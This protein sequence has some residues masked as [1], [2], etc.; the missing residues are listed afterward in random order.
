MFQKPLVELQEFSSLGMVAEC[1]GQPNFKVVSQWWVRLRIEEKPRTDE[2]LGV[3]PRFC[4][5]LLTLEV[6]GRAY[7]SGLCLSVR[8]R[9][10]GR[11][12]SPEP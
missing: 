6:E 3:W 2:A 10:V 8:K 1:S 4:Q 7:D 11:T 12:C 5:V 9:W